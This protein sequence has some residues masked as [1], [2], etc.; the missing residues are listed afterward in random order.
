[1]VRVHPDQYAGHDRAGPPGA[2]IPA[3]KRNGPLAAFRD[4]YGPE[5]TAQCLSPAIRTQIVRRHGYG[6]RREL[7]KPVHDQ[8]A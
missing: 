1:M 3:M 8:G 6:L 5:V 4:R 2:G 7:E